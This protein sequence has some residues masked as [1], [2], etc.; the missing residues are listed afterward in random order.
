VELE[1]GPRR[2]ELSLVLADDRLLQ[3]LNRSYRHQDAPTDVLAFPAGPPPAAGL[4]ELLGEV[5]ISVPTARRQA[6]EAGHDWR[7]EIEILLVHGI[8]HLLGWSD[9]KAS[10]RRRM[11]TRQEEILAVIDREYH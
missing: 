9:E 1:K 6:T 8:M 11:L 2:A 10:Q 4:P 3:E 5:V 7:R